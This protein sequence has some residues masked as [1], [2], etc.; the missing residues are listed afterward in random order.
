MEAAKRLGQMRRLTYLPAKL[1]RPREHLAHFR[2]R[3]SLDRAQSCAEADL[4]RQFL[5]KALGRF[6][7][8]LQQLQRRVEELDRLRMAGTLDCLLAGAPKI[9]ECLFDVGAALVVAG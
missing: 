6:R 9:F 5:L 4:E 2:R 1:A 7:Q 3:P 8:S